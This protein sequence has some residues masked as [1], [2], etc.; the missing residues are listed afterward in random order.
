MNKKFKFLGLAAFLTIAAM[1]F[2]ACGGGEAANE[3]DA[4]VITEE[5][6]VENETQAIEDQEGTVDVEE[7]IEVDSTDAEGKCGEGKCGE[8]KCG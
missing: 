7:V 8:G 3:S 2:T 5:L 4:E 1:G 6:E